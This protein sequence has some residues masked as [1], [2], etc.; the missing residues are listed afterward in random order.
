[1]DPN[2][3]SWGTSIKDE[4]VNGNYLKFC[5]EVIKPIAKDKVCLEIG[6]LD[7][8]WSVPISSNS[9]IT[10][11][12]DLDK[13]IESALNQRLNDN[14]IPKEKWEFCEINGYDLLNFKDNSIEFI[15]SIDSLTR[16]PYKSI[17]NYIYE[18]ARLLKDEN[19]I[20]ILHIPLS[21]DN[22]SKK[23]R[24]TDLHLVD[25]IEIL[26]D[27]NVRYSIKKITLR[28]VFLFIQPM[29]NEMQEFRK[30]TELNVN[31]KFR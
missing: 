9:K 29:K 6:C 21:E 12:C 5:D 1:M 23:M 7:G 2:S 4:K 28:G 15:F 20:A 10:Y 22:E 14:N 3:Y 17:K 8:K 25:L 24:F 11:L 31:F 16:A 27:L 26:G 30:M 13:V 18:S 19:S